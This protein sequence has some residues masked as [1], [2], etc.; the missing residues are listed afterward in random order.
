MKSELQIGVFGFGV[1]F[2]VLSALGIPVKDVTLFPASAGTA[3]DRYLEDFMDPFSVAVLRNLSVGAFNDL[4]KLVFLRESPGAVHAFHYACELKS[5]G[6]L[7]PGAPSLFLLNLIPSE[8]PAALRFNKSE[9]ARLE[10]AVG[11][12]V[13]T[14]QEPM[15]DKFK[16]FEKLFRMQTEGRI[17]GVEAFA[18]RLQISRGG[19]FPIGTQQTFATDPRPRLALLGAPLGNATLHGLLGKVGALIFDQQA[20]DQLMAA[21]GATLDDAL[22]G[23]AANPFA[24]RQPKPIYLSGLEEILLTQRIDGVFWQVDTHDD[25]WGWLTLQVFELC[26]KLGI[27]FTDLGLLPRWPT[28]KELSEVSKII[29]G[30]A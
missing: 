25:L 16:E 12:E 11:G 21:R 13:W 10:D 15:P 20:A 29:G 30:A 5:R 18:A 3:V 19:A 2:G 26:G 24:A 23:Q 9:L 1:P 17:A 8:E 4:S 14:T 7:S 27:D 22:A 6:L 28:L